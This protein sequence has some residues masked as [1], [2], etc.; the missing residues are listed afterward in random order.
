MWAK[1]KYIFMR[2]IGNSKFK[3]KRRDLD[4]LSNFNS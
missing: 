3:H 1:I 2:T 4:S